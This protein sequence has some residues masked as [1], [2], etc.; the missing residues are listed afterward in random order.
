[1]TKTD[2]I[3]NTIHKLMEILSTAQGWVAGVLLIVANYFAG[4]ETTVTLAVL[5][6]V[7]DGAWGIAAALKQGRFTLSE[8]ARDTIMKISVYG[9]AIVVFIAIDKLLHIG[10]GLTLSI[11]CT[12]IILV[13]FWSMSAS[14][15]ICFPNMPF[16]RLM[17]KALAGEIASKLGVEPHDVETT[18]E[19]LSTGRTG[20]TEMQGQECPCSRDAAVGDGSS[21]KR[22]EERT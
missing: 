21:T 16:L 5:A 19:S 13:E 22:K 20:R 17:K 8:L 9:T 18:L 1:M 11:I 6:I 14:A 4:Y 15:L 12:V 2:M 3:P 7:M 10:G